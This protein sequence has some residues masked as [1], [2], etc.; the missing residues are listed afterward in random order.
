M[1]NAIALFDPLAGIRDMFAALASMFRR[2]RRGKR[3]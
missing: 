3:H 2:H 1:M